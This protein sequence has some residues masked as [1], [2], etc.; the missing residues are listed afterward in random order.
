MVVSGRTK[1]GL[2]AGVIQGATVEAYT[3][4]GQPLGIATTTNDVGY[5]SINSPQLQI[6][7]VVKFSHV[8][9]Y[10]TEVKV[11]GVSNFGF[12]PLDRKVV[13]L[14]PVIVTSPDK[15]NSSAL[16]LLLLGALAIAGSQK[17]KVSGPVI[18]NKGETALL[19]GVAA[20]GFL[21]FDIVKKML[22]SIGLWK[23]QAVKDVQD[24]IQNPNSPF[25]P[26]FWKAAPAGALLLNTATCQQ[27]LETLTQAF[28]PFDDDES[29]ATGIFKQ[30]KTQSQV[31]FFSDYFSKNI[32]PPGPD[33]LTWLRGGAWPNDRLSAAE[34][35]DI[36]KY[37]K[38]L[39]KY[40]P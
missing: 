2:G 35:D 4:T 5:F 37:V 22:E 15:N 16:P 18:S 33:L 30:M 25:S 11:T 31:S 13:E 39:P 14:P 10:P 8:S 29:V 17:K 26:N 34:L 38:N 28:G 9:Y 32:F 23:S 6:G 21:G 19:I 7:D 12:I 36:V 1:D 24:E 3:A 20:V 27:Y 40:K